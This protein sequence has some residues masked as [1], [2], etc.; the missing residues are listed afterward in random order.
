MTKTQIQLP[1]D[2]YRQ[3]KAF[4]AEREWS[5]AETFRRGV[6]QLLVRYPRQ[7]GP[8]AKWSLPAPLD[9]GWRGLSPE[10]LHRAALQDQDPPP[11]R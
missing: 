11:P 7:S 2:L 5:M 10:E 4:A 6:E 9:L 3:V 8:A 1:D